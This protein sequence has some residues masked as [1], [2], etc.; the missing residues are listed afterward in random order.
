MVYPPYAKQYVPKFARNTRKNEEI[1]TEKK[2]FNE[3]APNASAS[4][5]FLYRK[6]FESITVI[7]KV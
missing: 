6:S 1:F 7:K 4:G 2:A 5:A 3:K